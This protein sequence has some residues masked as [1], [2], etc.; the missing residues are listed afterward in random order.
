VRPS[1][2]LC[3]V[4]KSRI[5][6]PFPRLF[7]DGKVARVSFFARLLKKP[8]QCR[9]I[10]ACSHLFWNDKIKTAE[11]S[12]FQDGKRVLD[13]LQRSLK[14]ADVCMQV[15][16]NGP[17][18]FLPTVVPDVWECAAVPSRRA[19]NCRMPR[20]I[21]LKPKHYHLEVVDCQIP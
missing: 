5:L 4:R 1:P 8:D 9:A 15:R 6:S 11:G 7:S 10:Y 3:R 16:K 13:C 12:S 20:F 19:V 17:L 2:P 18:M 21:T 14:I